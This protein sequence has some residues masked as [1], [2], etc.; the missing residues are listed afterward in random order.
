M[1]YSYTPV[2]LPT[3]EGAAFSGT[4]IPLI[5]RYH[6]RLPLARAT[7]SSACRRAPR[8]FCARR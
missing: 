4:H 6:E 7:N 1:T 8:R 5:E 2:P 3:V